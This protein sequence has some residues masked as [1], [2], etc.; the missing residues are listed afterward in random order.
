MVFNNRETEGT[1][2]KHLREHPWEVPE[3]K[4]LWAP[5]SCPGKYLDVH[6]CNKQ[7]YYQKQGY[8]ETRAPGWYRRE[9]SD[10]SLVSFTLQLSATFSNNNSLR[11]P[12]AL[13][14]LFTREAAEDSVPAAQPPLTPH[15]PAPE[16]LQDIPSPWWWSW[17][18]PE[19]LTLVAVVVHQDDLLEQGGGRV[20]DG[21]VHRAQDHRQCLVHKDEDDG[22]LGQV[23]PV[24][25]LFAPA[26]RRA[27]GGMGSAQVTGQ[28]FQ[29]G[30]W[31]IHWANPPPTTCKPILQSLLLGRENSKAEHP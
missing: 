24:F 19:L 25:Q 23:L 29:P 26:A 31:K 5:G 20:V 9:R 12:C 27:E 10:G 30:T 6:L 22:D 8:P 2:R 18:L 17:E 14:L 4:S 11:F 21:A 3:Q 16:P 13:I 15:G 1:Q 7:S 28:H